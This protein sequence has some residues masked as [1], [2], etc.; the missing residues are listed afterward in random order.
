LA[1][2]VV[3]AGLSACEAPF[4]LGQPSTRALENGIADGLTAAKRFEITGFYSESASRWSIDLQISRPDTRHVVIS[5]SDLKLEAILIGD[6]AYFRGNQF[7]SQHMGDDPIS[8][9]L[10]KAAGNAW[11]K[12]SA[13]DVPSLPDITDGSSFS[14]T[15]TSTPS[16]PPRRRP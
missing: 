10:V 12:G 11:W 5:K 16:P 15:R 3:L 9:N 7:L 1:G 6:A 13:A 4:G 14:L 8:R 2:A